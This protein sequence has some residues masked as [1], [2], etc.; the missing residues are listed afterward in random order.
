MAARFAATFVPGIGIYLSVGIVPGNL[1]IHIGIGVSLWDEFIAPA[2]VKVPF[3]YNCPQCRL[4]H[5]IYW[6]LFLEFVQP[7]FVFVFV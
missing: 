7:G 3:L 6:A 2:A 1:F 5:Q 4:H